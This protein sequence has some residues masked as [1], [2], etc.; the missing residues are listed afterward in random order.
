MQ[1]VVRS[2]EVLD[3]SAGDAFPDL[4]IE[5]DRSAPIERV[6]S[7]TIGTVY[8]PYEHWRTGDHHDRG[9]LLA[10][11]EG[12][13]P[14]LRARSLDL[15]EIAP[16]LAAA[17]G[18]ELADVDGRPRLDL[19]PNQ[20][21]VDRS[22]LTAAPPSSPA[23]RSA[24]SGPPAATVPDPLARFAEAALDLAH[25][26]IVTA[27]TAHEHVGAL[28][29]GPARCGVR[30]HSG[31][32]RVVDHALARDGH[33]RGGSAG[34]GDHA[35]PRPAS[36]ASPPRSGPSRPSATSAGRWWWS[37]TAVDTAKGVVADIGDDRVRL[38]EVQHGGP[39]AARNA[40]LDAATG[41]VIA[42]LDDD[43]L[44]DPGWLKA[45]VWAFQQRP[46]TEVLYGATLIDDPDRLHGR[47]AGGWPALAFRSFDRETLRSG[48]LADMGAI[49]HVAGLPEARFDERLW[50]FADWD[51]F[52]ALTEHRT[53]LELPAVALCYS[54]AGDDR[55]SGRHSHD[56]AIVREKWAI[57]RAEPGA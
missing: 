45:V 53:P 23:P 24:P 15:I 11:G 29:G 50:E 39:A 9:L 56:D 55:L 10:S 37:T 33:G 7:P 22:E 54:S 46:E 4:F 3:R 40:G 13:T 34:H 41:T 44:L 38:L 49:A 35:D 5:W 17:L 57:P 52:L 36:S 26:A 30:E 48:N 14:G 32:P 28:R 6:W 8:A 47:G 20:T 27:D 25:Q 2:E 19:V 12:I 31:E 16:T 21:T 42:Y 51:L 43:N 18:E 1:Q